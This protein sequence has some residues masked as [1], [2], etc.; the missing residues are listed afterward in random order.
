MRTESTP[1]VEMAL[2]VAFVRPHGYPGIVM[3]PVVNLEETIGKSV[4]SRKMPSDAFSY[5]MQLQKAGAQLGK[6]FDTLRHPRGVFKFHSHEEA[7][8]WMM[9]FLK[10]KKRV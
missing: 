5:G 3:K 7:D 8:A 9:K 6:R 4:G 1:S 10:S 2:H